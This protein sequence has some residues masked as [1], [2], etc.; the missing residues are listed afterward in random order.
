MIRWLDDLTSD[1]RFALRTL[2]TSPTFSAK[3]ALTLALTIG[4]NG[5]IFALA[6]ATILRPVRF[7]DPQ[8]L[9]MV[10]EQVPASARGVVAPFEF[11]LWSQRNQTF[12]SMAAIALG[13]RAVRG[14][15]GTAEQIPAQTVGTRLFDVL[16]VRPILGGSRAGHDNDRGHPDA[17]VARRQRRSGDVVSPAMIHRHEMG[18][19]GCSR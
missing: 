14:I 3:A 10:H 17:G 7:P 15:D 4:V 18:A 16:G 1:S 9:V 13:N 11:D 8:Q 12:E 5:A 19:L 6:D 2:K